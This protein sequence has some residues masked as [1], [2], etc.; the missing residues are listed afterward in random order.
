[1]LNLQIKCN[2]LRPS[3]EA[4]RVFQCPCIYGKPSSVPLPITS[5][6]FSAPDA[7]PKKRGPKTDVLEALLKR[8]DGLEKR[9]QD[10]KNPIS[11]T[12]PGKRT[13]E[14]PRSHS[15]SRR[16]TID[17]SSFESHDRTNNEPSSLSAAVQRADLFMRPAGRRSLSDFSRAAPSRKGGLSE[18]VLDLYFARLHGKPFYILDEPSVRKLHQRNELSAHLS[19]AILAMTL[20]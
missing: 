12:S 4:C 9:L 18:T 20:R 17:A 7:V 8:V 16:N 19:L 13:E 5:L 14:L 3:C 10:E 6:N 2:R 11:P 1:M 15:N